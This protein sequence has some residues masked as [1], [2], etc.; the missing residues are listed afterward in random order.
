MELCSRARDGPAHW[1]FLFWPGVAARQF[2]ERDDVL[3]HQQKK[4]E[5]IC[6]LQF[7]FR[8]D[9]CNLSSIISFYRL[10]LESRFVH[11]DFGDD[12]DDDD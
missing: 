7:E 4:N 3:M 6:S 9:D 11:C 2:V 10:Q 1:P 8:F 12:D 5:F